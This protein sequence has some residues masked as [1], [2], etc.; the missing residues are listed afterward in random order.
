VK[1]FSFFG[2]IRTMFRTVLAVLG[3]D[4]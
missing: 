3:K 1:H 4:Y 2:D